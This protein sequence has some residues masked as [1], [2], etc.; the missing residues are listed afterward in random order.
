MKFWKYLGTTTGKTLIKPFGKHYTFWREWLKEY[1]PEIMKEIK[2]Q[3]SPKQRAISHILRLLNIKQ[4]DY[5]HSHRR[6]VYLYP[7]YS[8]YREFLTEEI[9]E[10]DL[11]RL[12]K[13]EYE[14]TFVWW[15]KKSKERYAKLKEE[16]RLQRDILFHMIGK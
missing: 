10:K 14:Q 3:P 6:G 8:N 15:L 4:S 13:S 9:K 1:Y 11:V 5:F 12:H 2:T 7:I 16:G